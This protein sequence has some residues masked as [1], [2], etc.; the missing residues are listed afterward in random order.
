MRD[1]EPKGPIVAERSPKSSK[2][3]FDLAAVAAQ[4]SSK[5]LVAQ[6]GAK[7]D[8][9]K[10]DQPRTPLGSATLGTPKKLGAGVVSVISGAAKNMKAEGDKIKE[11]LK[12]FLD[13]KPQAGD[14]G[15][16]APMQID[17]IEKRLN[18]LEKYNNLYLQTSSTLEPQYVSSYIPRAFNS[19]FPWCVGGPD[20][21]RHA[22]TNTNH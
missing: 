19:T 12:S 9:A 22:N 21:P 6:D 11:K 17:V 14:D 16:P 2:G 8:G 4:A 5:N 18:A 13:S 20:F 7:Q 10:L 3:G 15:G 1:K